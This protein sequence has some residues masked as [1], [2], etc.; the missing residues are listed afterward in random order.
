MT[1]SEKTNFLVSMDRKTHARL[2]KK[3]KEL[4][5]SMS[6]LARHAITRMLDLKHIK[7]K[8]D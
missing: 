2:K 4:N 1:Y 3:A 8:L 6:V 5:I 7:I